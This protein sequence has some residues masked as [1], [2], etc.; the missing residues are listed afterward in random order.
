MSCPVRLNRYSI[1]PKPRG[2][3]LVGHVAGRALCADE[4]FFI[5]RLKSH[6]LHVWSHPAVGL[7]IHRFRA[8]GGC[9]QE[10][11]PACN[12]SVEGVE[13]GREREGE[14]GGGRGE[15][16]G[17]E[18]RKRRKSGK[19]K[20]KRR[21]ERKGKE[22]GEG[23]REGRGEGRGGEGGGGRGGKREREGRGGGGGGK[24]TREKRQ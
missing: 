8:K 20:R 14:R 13:D 15:K 9:N 3:A 11:V 17:K 19:E 21:K 2:E 18:K 22:R 1:S 6:I 7:P 12:R 23:R 5:N 24:T 16:G 4:D 10:D